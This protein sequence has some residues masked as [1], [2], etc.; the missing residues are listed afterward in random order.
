MGE[1]SIVRDQMKNG[2]GK[3]ADP[4]LFGTDD[5]QI[6]LQQEGHHQ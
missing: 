6:R 4:V 3:R 1:L 2:I 5:A